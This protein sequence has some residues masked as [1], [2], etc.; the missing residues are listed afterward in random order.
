[1]SI[2]EYF[3]HDQ[4]EFDIRQEGEGEVDEEVPGV[5]L[6]STAE[7]VT[8]QFRINDRLAPSY[9]PQRVIEKV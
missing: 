6:D 8:S 3:F 4:M 7:K 1:M 9:L 5:V 2:L